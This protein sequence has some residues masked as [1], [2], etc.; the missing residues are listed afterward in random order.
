LEDAQAWTQK[1]V[2]WY[3]QDH[4]HS[5]LK[6]V[7]PAQRHSGQAAAIL[8]RREQVYQKARNRNPKRWSQGA[9]NW[10][11]DDQ[12][13]LNPGWIRAEALKQAA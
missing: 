3:N 7:T 8:D 12:F 2:R 6:F 13:W 10:H 1:F 4:K 11:L 9:R 5:G